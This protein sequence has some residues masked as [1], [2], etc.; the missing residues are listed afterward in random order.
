MQPIY[1]EVGDEITTV[2]ERLKASPAKEVALVVPKGAVILQSIVNLKL[3]R[4]AAAD[5][6]RELTLVT[7]DKI[8]R[9]LAAQVGIANL[10][11]LEEGDLGPDSEIASSEEPEVIGGVRIHRYYDKEEQIEEP[12]E[13]PSEVEPIRVP[14][15]EPSPLPLSK[16]EEE[17]ASPI[18]VRSIS[19]DETP[20]KAPVVEIIR[21]KQAH[22][23]TPTSHTHKPSKPVKPGH[24]RRVLLFSLYLI[25]L[26]IIGSAAVGGVYLPATKVTIHVPG[27]PWSQDYPVQATVGQATDSTTHLTT[28]E[29]LTTSVNGT[30]TFRATGTKNIGDK[31]AGTATISYI[32]DSNSQTLP[33][34]TRLKASNLY[35]VTTAPVTVP[36]AKVVN[37]VPVAGSATVAVTAEAEGDAS[38]M[39][40]VPATVVASAS[41]YAQINQTTGGT[42]KQVTIVSQ[43]DIAN[44]KSDLIKKLQ[45]DAKAALDGQVANR[46]IISDSTTDTFALSDFHYSVEP[47]T[48]TD[49]AQVSG[50]GNA[51]RVIA[52]TTTLENTVNQLAQ[53]NVKSGNTLTI[54]NVSVKNPTFDVAKGTI[55]F[56][57]SA[58]GLTLPTVPVDVIR[59]QLVG[60]DLHDGTE[61]IKTIISSATTTIEQKPSWWPIKRFPFLSRYLQ[62]NISHE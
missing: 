24:R 8:G 38:N 31:A 7:T 56:T 15:A 30:I 20:V 16:E 62:I 10:S 55:N 1:V 19:T 59:N 17:D 44:A 34:G 60:K 3:I 4:K 18:I 57:A 47:G 29:S 21:P 9:N 48:Q 46:T 25:L 11:H 41:F 50:T 54:S 32:Q 45:A 12:V 58:T 14:P 5:T 49:Q 35:F 6:K 36:G 22:Q 52:D 13:A 33:A 28:A 39:T 40:N 27:Q 42:T 2:I 37:A 53:G 61:L 51:K 23:K 26:L 43:T